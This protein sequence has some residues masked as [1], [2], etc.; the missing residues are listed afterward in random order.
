MIATSAR[1]RAS[2]VAPKTAASTSPSARHGQRP[3]RPAAAAI[4]RDD[5]GQLEAA[6]R[7]GVVQVD[8]DPDTDAAPQMPKTISRCA[9]MSP[10]IPAG[11][12]RRRNPR[13]SPTASSSNSAVPT[14]RKMPFWGKATIW[15]SMTSR[16]ALRMLEQRVE[17]GQSV[18]G[19]DV[20]MAGEAIVPKRDTCATKAW[21]R[22]PLKSARGAARLF[23]RRPLGNAVA[24]MRLER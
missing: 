23:Q 7:A 9:V 4:V 20:D 3:T 6:E 24:A 8:I 2:A 12:R 22:A 19:V 13:Q 17:V 1:A 11:S 15:M 21:A 10:S 5:V 14:S 16:T 18:V